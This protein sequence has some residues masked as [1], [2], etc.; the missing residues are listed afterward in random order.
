[1]RAFRKIRGKKMGVLFSWKGERLNVRS[2]SLPFHPA[3][4]NFAERLARRRRV[5]NTPPSIAY[6]MD[7]LCLNY[8]SGK[9][10][11]IIRDIRGYIGIKIRKK[12]ASEMYY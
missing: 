10:N 7:T 3:M 5:N 4:A 2:K 9:V 12:R 6:G 1:M 8:R 11:V